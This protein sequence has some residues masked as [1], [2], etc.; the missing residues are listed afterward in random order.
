[1]RTGTDAETVNTSELISTIGNFTHCFDENFS[2]IEW[3]ISSSSLVDGY[4]LGD[5]DGDPIKSW[6][7]RETSTR[8]WLN[9]QAGIIPKG[10]GLGLTGAKR[11]Q[12]LEVDQFTL[13]SCVCLDRNLKDPQK[14]AQVAAEYG[15]IYS[16]KF[17]V[18]RHQF[19]GSDPGWS[20]D[21]R[22][23]QGFGTWWLENLGK[24]MV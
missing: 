18:D 13:D 5:P 12:S 19:L 21:P 1:M 11:T 2:S 8:E 10:F 6:S 23:I 24:M 14:W 17:W 9:R 7:N 4:V 3:A 15:G 20:V 22:W 16:R